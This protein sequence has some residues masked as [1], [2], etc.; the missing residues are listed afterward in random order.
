MNT[1]D[2][3]GIGR[4]QTHFS[5]WGYSAADGVQAAS[6]CTKLMLRTAVELN[7]GSHSA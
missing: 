3:I 4:L 6:L 7:G 5:S 1:D 2:K